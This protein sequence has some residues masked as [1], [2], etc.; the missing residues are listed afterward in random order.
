MDSAAAETPGAERDENLYRVLSSVGAP[1]RPGS[2]RVKFTRAQQ[3]WTLSFLA[4]IPSP[5]LAASLLGIHSNKIFERRKRD[6]LFKNEY[7]DAIAAGREAT[8][9]LAY[10]EA[11]GVGKAYVLTKDGGLVAVPKQRSERIILALLNLQHARELKHHTHELEVSGQVGLHAVNLT[12][13]QYMRLDRAERKTLLRLVE[14]ATAD[15]RA[16]P[17]LGF[18]HAV[19]G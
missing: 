3:R 7:D 12:P 19:E 15:A 18:G 2:G 10:E 16:P 11:H 8:V 14:K 13:E 6:P 4:Q 9:S 17:A 5:M 1:P